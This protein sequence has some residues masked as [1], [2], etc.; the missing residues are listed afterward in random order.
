MNTE[1]SDQALLDSYS[2]TVSGVAARVSP[3]VVKIEVEKGGRGGAGS[4]FVFTPNGYILTNSHVVG[5]ARSVDVVLHDGRRFPAESVGDDPH[6]DLA[7]VRVQ[8]DGL[9]TAALGESRSLTPGQLAIAIGNPYGFSYSV[10]AGV[11]SALGRSLRSASGRLMDDII[12]TDAALNPGNSGGPLVDSAGRVIGVNSAVILPAQGLCF[13]IPVDTAKRVAGQL[14]LHGR[15]RRGYLGFGGQNVVVP[16]WL[17]KRLGLS[18]EAG[19]LVI[20]VEPGGP[21]ARAGLREGDLIVGFSGRPLS[22]VDQLHKALD[23]ASIGRAHSLTVVRDGGREE[24][25]I[26][27]KETP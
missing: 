20:A 13:A 3:A 5:G 18:A 12:Q 8:A 11:I 1:Q 23:E 10:T 14:I 26:T 9:P 24:L 4:G 25:E 17:A 27:P 19:V 21:A 7:V 16:R 6:T 22:G 2:R 15:L